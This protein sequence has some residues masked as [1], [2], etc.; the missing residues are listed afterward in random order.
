MVSSLADSNT[1][2]QSFADR[3]W[4]QQVVATGQPYLGMAVLSRTTGKPIMP[5]NIPI[6][7]DRQQLQG[8]F[9]AGISLGVLSDTIVDLD[10]GLNTEVSI[11]CLKHGI[12]LAHPD[13][14]RILTAI[15]GKNEAVTRMTAIISSR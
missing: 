2:G 4:F 7:D 14:T 11:T 6:F 15:S 8:I 12:I 9:T 5:Y 3:E 13:S 10:F 1:I